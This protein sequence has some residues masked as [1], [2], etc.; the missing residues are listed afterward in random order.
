[1]AAVLAHL[2]RAGMTDWHAALWFT[3][4]TGWLDDRRP[5]EVLDDDPSAV[6]T[7]AGRFDKRLT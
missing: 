3:S 2:R 5:V 6:E 1:M 4:P 7:A